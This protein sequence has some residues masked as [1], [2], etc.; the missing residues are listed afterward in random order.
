M[1]NLFFEREG[2]GRTNKSIFFRGGQW[3]AQN[4]D[5]CVEGGGEPDVQI[6]V[7]GEKNETRTYNMLWGEERS[8]KI[9]GFGGGRER[10]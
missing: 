5:V 7:V 1:H 4:N 9:N 3:D 10:G 2:T 6:D 8:T